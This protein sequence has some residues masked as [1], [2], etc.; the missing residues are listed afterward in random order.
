MKKFVNALGVIFLFI[1]IFGIIGKSL[2]FDMLEKNDDPN[3]DDPIVNPGGIIGP[4][5]NKP[6][7]ESRIAVP[8]TGYVN[9]VYVDT[10]LSVDE[11]VSLLGE[12]TLNLGGVVETLLMT[13]DS[14]INI[15][16]Q[17]VDGVWAIA[18]PQ[19]QN[20]YF[21]SQMV[22]DR[23]FV[24]WNPNITYPIVVNSN[25][26]NEMEGKGLGT[27]NDKLID[28][29]YTYPS[30]LIKEEQTQ[31]ERIAVPNTGYVNKVYY[32]TDLSYDEVVSILDS[33]DFPE[34]GVYSIFGKENVEYGF[35]GVCIQKVDNE[36]LIID[37][38][39]TDSQATLPVFWTHNHPECT[40]GVG[41]WYSSLVNPVAIDSVVLS[42]LT[43]DEQYLSFGEQND[44]LIDLI[45][46][47][48]SELIQE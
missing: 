37:N 12:L 36:Y 30:E 17:Y 33:I 48:P 39:I 4:G 16:V 41:G 25:V 19:N 38:F 24:G 32:N 15:L 21:Y 28:L 35:S 1:L 44:K 45:Y 11:V 43:L 26:L 22:E 9:K 7:V 6:S 8:N 20:F 29:F 27:Q 31:E 2:D 18:D 14:S 5:T 3:S 46:T 47:Y 40:S 10:S 34:H 23:N 42:E 13:E